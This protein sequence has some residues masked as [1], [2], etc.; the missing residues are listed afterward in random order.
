MADSMIP[1]S[2]TPGTKAKAGEVNANFVALADFIETFKSN[3]TENFDEIETSLN[4]INTTLSQKADKEELITN[5]KVNKAN[6]NLNNYKTPGNYIFSSQYP[7]SNA[8]EGN[9]GIL[10]VLGASDTS[11]TQVWYGNNSSQTYYRYF[12]NFQWSSWK[13]SYGSYIINNPGC[14]K[15]SNGIMIQWGQAIT[16]KQVTYPVAYKQL[17]CPVFMKHGYGTSTERSDT[18]FAAQSLTGFTAGTNGVYN[19]LNWIAVGW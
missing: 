7:S 12:T 4:G 6:E 13:P 5:F 15:F 10:M 2:F 1:Y 16:S 18:G 3:S 8:P 11:I 17:A 9:V 14:L 19:N